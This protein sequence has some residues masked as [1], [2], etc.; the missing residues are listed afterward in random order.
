MSLPPLL[1]EPVP[2]ATAHAA[3]ESFRHGHPYLALRDALGPLYSDAQF[4]DLF[5]PLGAP[6]TRP[7]RLALVL[8]LQFAEDLSDRDAADAVRGRLDWK[9]LLG[10]DLT[11]PGFDASVLSEFRTRLITGSAEAR[12]LDA[13]LDCF[14]TAGLLRRRTRAR[15]DSTHVL[16]AVRARNRL[17][18]VGE[19]VR[20]ALNTL[21]LVLPDQ[22]LEHL[23]PAW[24]DRYRS[25]FDEY[26][27]PKAP[28]ERTD[29]AAKIGADGATLLEWVDDASTPAWVRRLPALVTLRRVWWQQYERTEQGWRWRAVAE[30]PPA[31]LM[32]NNPY[33]VEARYSC[34]R[35]TTWT[36]YKAHFT[37]ICEPDAPHLITAVL[38]TAA[39]TPDW[40][41]LPLIHQDLADKDLLPAEEIVDAGYV[42]S[43]VLVNS[44]ATFGVRVVGPV[45]ADHSWQAQS[46]SGFAIGQFVVD[47]DAQQVRCPQGVASVKWSETHDSDGNAIINVRFPK[48]VCAGCG[49]RE[50][51]TRSRQG[52]RELSLRPREQHEALQAA[53]A[54]QQTEEFAVE[55]QRRAGIEGT[56]SQGVRVSGLRQSRYI[57]EA[58]TRLGDLLTA[59]G[60]NVRRAGAWLLDEVRGDTD[61]ARPRF[62]PT[63]QSPFARLV[64]Q[65]LG[66]EAENSPVGAVA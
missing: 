15:T 8:V 38:T 66:T 17:E 24:P 39:T 54:D 57:G 29:L 11:D 18:C 51:C 4:T 1:P 33:D 64:S 2:A 7:W 49:R 26:R 42:D 27:L 43:E 3:Q 48:A 36:G 21:A 16:A 40:H 60:L 50:D 45:P 46:P 9:Y 52:P 61:A 19:T 34:K 12:L 6:A 10:L 44:A 55:Y 23:D 53:R 59:A 5:S 62:A 31:A 14:Y 37:E 47:W 56:I 28:P 65:V 25:P 30:L 32:I 22:L 13:L 63:R 20:A 58:K 41:A 35:S